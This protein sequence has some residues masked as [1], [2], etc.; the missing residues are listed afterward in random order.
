[1]L[2]MGSMKDGITDKMVHAGNSLVL[3]WLG[4]CAL[5]AE[6]LG[7]VSGHGTKIPQATFSATTKHQKNDTSKVSSIVP[8][9]QQEL[10]NVFSSCIEH[11]FPAASLSRMLWFS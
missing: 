3:Q 5:T 1:M 7:S 9:L 2:I 10:E 4:L 11:A 6:G 8:D